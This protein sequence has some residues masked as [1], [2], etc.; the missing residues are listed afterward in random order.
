MLI[1][2]DHNSSRPITRQVVEQIHWLIVSERLSPGERLP[3]IRNLS[4][5]LQVNPTTITRIYSELA[6]TGV[7]ILRRGQG[8]FVANNAVSISRG[9]AEKK[10]S[11]LARNMLVEGLRQ[12]LS[13]EDID[14][15]VTDEF[16]HIRN[17]KDDNSN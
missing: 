11:E 14:R 7:I 16:Q 2:I 5:Q 4:K 8:A 15:L 10:I 13:K 9:D 1:H 12:G 6:H 17:G 3:S